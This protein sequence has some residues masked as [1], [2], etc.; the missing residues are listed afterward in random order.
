MES[1]SHIFQVGN[2]IM[3]SGDS[4]DDCPAIGERRPIRDAAAGMVR[5]WYE[6]TA[7]E[8]PKRMGML[9]L[10]HGEIVEVVW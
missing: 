1:N 6:V 9:Y 5:A 10:I 4:P 7:V 8:P 3:T 2:K